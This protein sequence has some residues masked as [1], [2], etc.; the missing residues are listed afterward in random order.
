MQRSG[1]ILLSGLMV[2]ALAASSGGAVVAQDEAKP[3]EGVNLA[4]WEYVIPSTSGIHEKHL[5]E[6]TELTGA[7]V[8]LTALPEA[9]YL[10]K[11]QLAQLAGDPAP[12]VY[13][14]DFA[15]KG[16]VIER[17]AEEYLDTYLN[18]PA[19]TP[20]DY[21]VGDFASGPWSLCQVDGQQI[22][23]PFFGNG[24]F[25]YYNKDIFANAGIE[26]PPA[27]IADVIAAAK[28][29]HDPDNGI[30]GLCM[31][32]S[33]ENANQFTAYQ[34]AGYYLPFDDNKA[35]VLDK[36]YRPIYD[37]PEALAWINDYKELMQN[38]APDGIQAYGYL[39]CNRDFAAGNVAMYPE[40]DGQIGFFLDP[41][42]SDI[43][44]SVGFTVLPCEAINP[45]H[46]T[47]YA[48]GGWFMN[49]KA[50]DKLAAWE[51]IKWLTNHENQVAW[52]IEG[53]SPFQVVRDSALP[54]VID[55]VGFPEEVTDALN[56][57]HTH[58][59]PAPFPPISNIGDMVVATSKML[60]TIIADQVSVEDGLAIA[61]EDTTD[62]MIEFGYLEE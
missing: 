56:Y 40:A 24:T 36:D 5:A 7:T 31:R 33:A 8:E 60:T 14:D 23:I 6:F 44:D 32:G 29:T 25:F 11:L 55:G 46:C 38:Y 3:F 59:H 35:I 4:L 34:L 61:Q 1:R 43:V 28:A 21:N 17:G 47:V 48:G 9:D 26:G 53:N 62:S 49:N 12:D 45:D 22:C 15:F 52:G 58:A 18:D 54:L 13:Y 37:T 30:S 16:Q 39:E 50:K 41:E 51:L 57:Q 27:S 19:L 42:T 20:E 10:N 2:A